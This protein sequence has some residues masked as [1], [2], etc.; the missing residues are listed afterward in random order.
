MGRTVERGALTLLPRAARSRPGR[1]WRL[2][3][4]RRRRFRRRGHRQDGHR[5]EAHDFLGHAAEKE[6]RDAS[7]AVRADDDQVRVRLGGDGHDRVPGRTFLPEDGVD[8]A[9]SRSKLR[10]TTLELR[11]HLLTVFGRQ[12]H[13]VG[14]GSLERVNERKLGVQRLREVRPCTDCASTQL[15][16]PRISGGRLRTARGAGVELA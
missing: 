6:V 16:R 14:V 12:G 8:V 2:T 4:V 5:R 10:A 9:H 11:A 7:A 1:G 3:L 15:L 13:R